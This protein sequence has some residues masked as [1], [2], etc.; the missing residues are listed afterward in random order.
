M[1]P[2]LSFG[3]VTFPTNTANV[4][5]IYPLN[6]LCCFMH[7][8]VCLLPPTYLVVLT[9]RALPGERLVAQVMIRLASV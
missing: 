6:C 9:E 3:F 4:T 1:R 8:G 5:A 2:T 7:Q